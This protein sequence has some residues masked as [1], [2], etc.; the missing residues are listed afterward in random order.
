MPYTTP[1]DTL[2]NWK[3]VL[4]NLIHLF[5]F[6]YPPTSPRKH[7]FVPSI[8]MNLFLLCFVF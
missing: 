6:F 3:F 7:Q 1:R 5:H 2:Y 4:L 8:Y